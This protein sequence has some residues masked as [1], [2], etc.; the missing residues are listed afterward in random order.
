MSREHAK[1]V[2]QILQV[3]LSQTEQILPKIPSANRRMITP[4]NTKNDDSTRK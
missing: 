4:D 3:T 2:L 1:S